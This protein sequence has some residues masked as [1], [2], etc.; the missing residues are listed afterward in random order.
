MNADHISNGAALSVAVVPAGLGPAVSS[1]P[2][3]ETHRTGGVD[4]D[5]LADLV[6][7]RVVEMLRAPAP[8]PDEDLAWSTSR[9]AAVLG[10]SEEWVRD[11]RAELGVIA[12]KGARPRLMFDPVAVRAFATAREEGVR[13]VVRD[14]APAQEMS[15]RR[16]RRIR[17]DAD[18]LPI[19]G[20]RRAA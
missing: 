3:P 19:R 16:P 4:L 12:V 20:D 17:T 1:V 6:A 2:E 14:A 13:S 10:M 7:L 5:V 11:H 9:V 18:L 8:T 15:P